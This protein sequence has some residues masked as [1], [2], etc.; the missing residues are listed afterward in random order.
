MPRI[1]ASPR[2][3][4]WEGA[5]TTLDAAVIDV[6][7]GGVR[8]IERHVPALEQALAGAPA[9]IALGRSG[10]AKVVLVDGMAEA[11]AAAVTL[12]GAPMSGSGTPQSP[13][14]AVGSPAVTALESP[15]PLIAMMLGSYYT[16]TGRPAEAVRVLEAGLALPPAV[17]DVPRA[18]VPLLTSERATALG[19]MKRWT[20]ALAAW[21]RALTLPG[22]SDKD[23]G[24][25]LRGKGVALIELK[26]YNE[27]ELTFR[28]SLLA[29]PQNAV[30]L[31]EL[32]YIEAVRAGRP[33]VAPGLTM[34]NAP[35]R[36]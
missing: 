36:P 4:P 16:E 7:L 17:P 20:E 24:R 21:D 19:R 22:L 5:R 15:Y 11:M 32:K 13:E 9:A 10:P 25:M 12:A 33:P 23:R 27:A 6:R 34:P 35:Q 28:S 8:A 31:N 14:Q 3:R 29:D 18:T 30:A 1:R 26:R 2:R